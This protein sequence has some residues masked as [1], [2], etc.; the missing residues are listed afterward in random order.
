MQV[1][2]IQVPESDIMATNGVLHF[3]DQ[4]LYPAGT[5]FTRSTF[6][7]SLMCAIKIPVVFVSLQSRT[8][9]LFL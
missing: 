7:A 9:V 1:N 6:N 3:V 2:S 5:V 4:V 8:P